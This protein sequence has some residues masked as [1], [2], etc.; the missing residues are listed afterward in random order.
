VWIGLKII[1]PSCQEKTDLVRTYPEEP[2]RQEVQCSECGHKFE[3]KDEV[4][5]AILAVED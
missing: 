5:A 4:M 2:S 1:C 3:G